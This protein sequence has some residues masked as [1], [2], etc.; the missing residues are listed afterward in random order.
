MGGEKVITYDPLWV[1]IAK[2]KLKKK[3][4]YAVVSSATVARMAKDAQSVSMDVVDK[5]CSF[6]G[7]SISDIAEYIPA[8]NEKSP[9]T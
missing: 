2:K 3:D 7:C 8:E 4:L 1:T 6:L 9:D 5:L